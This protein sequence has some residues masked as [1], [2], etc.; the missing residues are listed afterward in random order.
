MVNDANMTLRVLIS[1]QCSPA[2][3]ASLRSSRPILVVVKIA[4]VSVRVT[5]EVKGSNIA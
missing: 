1:K 3:A 4:E 2:N 5:L